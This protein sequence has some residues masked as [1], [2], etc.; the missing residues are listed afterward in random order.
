[1]GPGGSR[2]RFYKRGL[3]RRVE[4][5]SRSLRRIARPAPEAPDVLRR[6]RGVGVT[7]VAS[8]VG[9]VEAAVCVEGSDDGSSSGV[10]GEPFGIETGDGRSA[11]NPLRDG[12][13]V[14]QST[15][16]R[17]EDHGQRTTLERMRR[18]F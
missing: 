12:L 5:F 13:S 1:M 15:V 6:R 14:D 3:Q 16:E 11:R 7:Y 10:R 4:E 17:C 9:E 2:S 8:D 18:P